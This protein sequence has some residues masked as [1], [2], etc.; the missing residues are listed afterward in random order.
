MSS[1]TCFEYVDRMLPGWMVVGTCHTHVGRSRVDK[2]T[3]EEGRERAES[4]F[5]NGDVTRCIKEVLCGVCLHLKNGGGVLM[6]LNWRPSYSTQA[7]STIAAMYSD[8]YAER[9]WTRARGGT[10]LLLRSRLGL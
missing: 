4:L 10:S 2:K 8:D 5:L 7:S 9:I 3:T 6:L 1:D